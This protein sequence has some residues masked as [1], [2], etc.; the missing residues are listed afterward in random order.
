[1]GT[2]LP[3]ESSR[4]AAIF[5]NSIIGGERMTR[6]RIFL[7][8]LLGLFLKRN[9]ERELEEKIRSHFEMQI[10]D[11][12]KQGM[13][14]EEA[15]RAARLSFGGVA[16]VKEAYQDQS[17]LR[18]IEDLWQ[19]LRFGARMLLKTPGFTLMAVLTLS[20][21]IGANTAIFSVVNMFLFRPLPVE[22]PN[23]LA[24]I[25]AGDHPGFHSYPRYID[26]RDYNNVFSGLAAHKI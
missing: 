25:F 23:E 24:S 4:P 8:R 20:L 17:R 13:S 2:G 18:W 7:H 10:E 3:G 26:L 11:N 5:F 21:G 9:L 12:L 1:M 14:L 15:Q 16:Q 19:D 6:L 22:R